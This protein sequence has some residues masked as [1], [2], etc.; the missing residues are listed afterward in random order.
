MHNP[1][2][3]KY[4]RHDSV[5]MGGDEESQKRKEEHPTL[6]VKV[7]DEVLPVDNE[8]QVKGS[9]R[10]IETTLKASSSDISY[11]SVWNMWRKWPSSLSILPENAFESMDL[12]R[13]L[14][15]M[16]EAPINSFD[17]GYKGTQLKATVV[18]EG[19]QMVVFKPKRYN[20][21]VAIKGDPYAGFDRHDGEIA[22][23]HLDG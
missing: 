5:V 14:T 23:F 20:S 13:L 7:T 16:A 11:P 10:R 18:L 19:G 15:A 12:N 3:R 17:V 21:N 1:G 2:F 8:F 6:V 4:P 22:A 9:K